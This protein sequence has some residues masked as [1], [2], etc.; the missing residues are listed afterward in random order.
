MITDA[1]HDH[2]LEKIKTDKAKEMSQLRKQNVEPLI[3]NYKQDLGFREYLTLRINTVKNELN[4]VFTAVN[5]KKIYL[6]NTK[7]K[8]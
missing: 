5:L 1:K 8:I 4:L 7:V 6:L 2:F 3:G